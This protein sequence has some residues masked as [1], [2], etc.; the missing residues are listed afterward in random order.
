MSESASRERAG[1]IGPGLVV[2]GRIRGTGDLRVEGVVE[3]EI[4]LDG[5]LSLG[6]AATVVAP[7]S[8]R[9]VEIEGELHGS[10]SA[11]RD[12]SVRA[13][14][15]VRGDV[16]AARLSIDDGA[17]IDGVLEMDFELGAV[18][19]RPGDLRSGDP[20]GDQRSDR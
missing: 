7:V 8:G 13:G 4:A 6:A 12:L 10:V 19:F 18:D 9:S 16:R 14:G 2:M 20:R 5:D 11:S 1:V 15:R 3:G 17:V